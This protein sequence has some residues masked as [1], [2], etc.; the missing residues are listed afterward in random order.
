MTENQTKLLDK[1]EQ[2]VDSIINEKLTTEEYVLINQ[3]YWYVKG[4]KTLDNT[5]KKQKQQ[6]EN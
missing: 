2:C 1:I 5:R 4:I 6:R 3:I